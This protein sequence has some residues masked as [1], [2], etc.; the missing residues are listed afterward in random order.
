MTQ[1]DTNYERVIAMTT[2]T[3]T[4]PA[5]TTLLPDGD[6]LGNDILMRAGAA[7]VKPLVSRRGGENVVG[8][9]PRAWTMGGR[10]D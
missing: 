7:N 3:M 6:K 8:Y 10:V 9:E 4:K 5:E 2:E 1:V